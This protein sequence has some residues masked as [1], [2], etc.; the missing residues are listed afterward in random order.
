MDRAHP[1]TRASHLSA[2]LLDA[3]EKGS[4]SELDRACGILFSQKEPSLIHS[5]L[6]LKTRLR[7]SDCLGPR[8]IQGVPL[9]Y[10]E[11]KLQSV[12]VPLAHR[13]IEAFLPIVDQVDHPLRW[14]AIHVLAET[15]HP[16][17]F[18]FLR[19]QV[20]E[21]PGPHK[22]LLLKAIGLQSHEHKVPFLC[23]FFWDQEEAVVAQVFLIFHQDQDPRVL[24]YLRA[25]LADLKGDPRMI[26]LLLAHL[27]EDLESLVRSRT[28]THLQVVRKGSGDL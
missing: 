24:P 23:Q 9:H 20:L 4:R 11:T 26:A 22:C 3:L 5:L 6:W 17:I 10:R 13:H 19:R 15:R 1:N 21:K 8:T 27:E 16:R 2:S 28:K 18:E 12:L 25:A 14:A 7:G